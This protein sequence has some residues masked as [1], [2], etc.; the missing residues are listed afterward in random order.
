MS[1]VGMSNVSSAE[2]AGAPEAPTIKRMIDRF[3]HASP[4]SREDRAFI[5]PNA[6]PDFWWTKIAPGSG[7]LANA[8]FASQHNVSYTGAASGRMDQRAGVASFLS[9]TAPAS[10]TY[11]GGLSN[12]L[13]P[14]TGRN[15]AVAPSAA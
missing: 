8:S 9:D 7:S 12:V 3:R 4:T 11:R 10:Y 6:K 2:V 15:S 14:H 1:A 13:G 5:D